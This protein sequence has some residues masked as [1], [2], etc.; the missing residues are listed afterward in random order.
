MATQEETKAL[1]D[2]VAQLLD[3]MG[4]SGTSVCMHAKAQARIAYEPFCDHD[5]WEPEMS[6]IE[7]LAIVDARP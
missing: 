2:A 5:D 4:A 7:A 1:A 3:D 6:L